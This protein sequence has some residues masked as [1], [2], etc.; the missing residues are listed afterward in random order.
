MK[1][2]IL[3]GSAVLLVVIALLSR[4]VPHPWNLTPLTA[5]ALFAGVYLPR[6]YGYLVPLTA[7]V[8][9][10]LIIGIHDLILFTWGSFIVVVLIGWW[11]RKHKSVLKIVTGGLAGS[12]FFFL[13]TN[14]A[15]MQF[16]TMYPHS[17]SGLLSSYTAGIPF[18]RNMLI[19]D[20]V[21]VAVLFGI[22]EVALAAMRPRRVAEPI[23]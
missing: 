22:Y 20:L 17:W 3:I 16:G 18:F 23:A 5:V 12:V 10:D 1:K 2:Y 14:W 21:Y 13:V 15:V 6:R 19:G 8:V 9:S 7:L 11:V 4:V